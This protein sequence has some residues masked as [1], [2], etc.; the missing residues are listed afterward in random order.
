M[1][2]FKWWIDQ[3]VSSSIY[4]RIIWWGSNSSEDGYCAHHFPFLYN[5]SLSMGLS[6]IYFPGDW[7]SFSAGWLRVWYENR[8][9]I[10]ANWYQGNMCSLQLDKWTHSWQMN[11]DPCYTLREIFIVCVHNV[12]V[13]THRQYRKPV[14]FGN[15]GM[16]LQIPVIQAEFF[17]G[18]T[19]N[20]YGSAERQS[21]TSHLGAHDR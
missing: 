4:L 2:V 11:P 18:P 5:F 17:P 12:R 7:S 13:F 15:L 20:L 8:L 21:R 16:W 14:G 19:S 9:T 3:P 10:S 1:W 6:S